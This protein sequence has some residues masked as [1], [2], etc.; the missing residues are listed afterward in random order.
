M[1]DGI[2]SEAN[3]Y[4][5][6]IAATAEIAARNIVVPFAETKVGGESSGDDAIPLRH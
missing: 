4:R 3:T 5:L 2:Y 1:T 6:Y